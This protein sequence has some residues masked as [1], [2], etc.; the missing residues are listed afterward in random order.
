MDINR[1]DFV[2]LIGGSLFGLAVG[3]AAGAMLKLPDSS[4]PILYSGPRIES[5][6]LT[7]CTKCPGGCS[8]RIRL[9]DGLPIQAFGNPKSPVNKGGIC[10]LGL[11]SV[12]DIYH[13][14]RLTGPMKKVNGKF[15]PVSYNEAFNLLSSNLKKIISGKKQ[16]EVFVVAQTE[17]KLRAEL[18]KIFSNETGFKNLILDRFNETS[19]FPYI[20]AAGEAPDFIDFDK[21]DFLLNF[22]SQLTEI[23]QS[24]LYFTRKINEYRAKGFRIT[25]VQPRLTP[26]ISMLDDW[27]PLQPN[28]FG[29]FALGIA[30]VLIK[31]EQYDKNYQM[32]KLRSLINKRREAYYKWNGA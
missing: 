31:D 4:K 1:R 12:A 8:L 6:K 3:S 28:Q 32:S 15:Q 16:D 5:W 27:I 29:T 21:C 11:A 19:S 9:I 2:K 24:P 7:A 20:K 14:S 22:G 13:P 30:Y 10:P 18:F 23:S 17:S 25:A 26:S